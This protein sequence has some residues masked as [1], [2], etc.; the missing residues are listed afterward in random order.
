MPS[1]IEMSRRSCR[2]EPYRRAMLAAGVFAVFP[3]RPALAGVAPSPGNSLRAGTCYW[4]HNHGLA[5][6]MRDELS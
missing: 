1:D 3:C 4:P 5:A 6:G 2:W